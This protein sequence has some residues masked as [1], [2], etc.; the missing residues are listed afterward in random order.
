MQ[1]GL[2]V[3]SNTASKQPVDKARRALGAKNE[4]G[5]KC[6]AVFVF[7]RYSLI[8][9]MDNNPQTRTLASAVSD[10]AILL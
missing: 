6:L 1:V 8:S 3:D 5:T 10:R 7:K 2:N 9:W 4:L